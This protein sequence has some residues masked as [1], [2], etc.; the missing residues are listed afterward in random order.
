MQRDFKGERVAKYDV[1][2]CVRYESHRSNSRQLR[3]SQRVL[4]ST[5][6]SN[7]GERKIEMMSD[8]K[9]TFAQLSNDSLSA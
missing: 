2:N 6:H 4:G 5:S 7:S 8:L 3:S 9:V 1:Q